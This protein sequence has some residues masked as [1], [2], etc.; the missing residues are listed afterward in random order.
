MKSQIS[1]IVYEKIHSEE[2]VKAFKIL[3]KH[4]AALETH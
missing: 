2:E 1:M 3:D 4:E